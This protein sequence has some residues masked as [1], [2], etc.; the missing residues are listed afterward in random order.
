MLEKNIGISIDI[1]YIDK[2]CGEA[3]YSYC[4]FFIWVQCFS[5]IF[6]ETVLLRLT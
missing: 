4:V 2:Q 5:N 1:G 6:D 3:S